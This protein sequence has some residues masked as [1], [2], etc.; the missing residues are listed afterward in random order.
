MTGNIFHLQRFSLFDG[1][2][3]RTVVFLKGCPL[4]CVWCHNPEGIAAGPQIMYHA[5][6]CIGCG[7]CGMVCKKGAHVFEQGA[8]RYDRSLCTGCG[9]C[10]A[11]CCTQA[12]SLAGR[13]VSVEEIMAEIMKDQPY[14]RESGGGVTLSGG[15]PLL[16]ADFAIALLKEIKEQGLTG[17]VET[18]GMADADKLMMAA[19][20]TDL[21][22]F[23]YKATGE[24]MHIKLC[25]APQAP[26]L[27]NLARLEDVHARVVLRCPMVPGANICK[28][29]ILG[30]AGTARQYACIYEVQLEPFHRLGIGKAEKLGIGGMYD[31]EPPARA[32]LE[33]YC[34]EIAHIS[35]KSCVIS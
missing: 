24:E 18:C 15:E 5:G 22:Y 11:I 21:F 31:T 6:R 19:R 7:D 12:L 35:G 9:D 32:E 30:I 33:R 34:C 27:D 14:Y 23:D 26:I 3:I 10:A 20:F 16:Q 17:C 28:K 29:H 1:P 2:G 13:Q 4:R 8:H 25:G